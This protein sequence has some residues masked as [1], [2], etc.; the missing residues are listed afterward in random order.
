M[1]TK[2][3]NCKTSAN[4]V[5]LLFCYT[6][7]PDDNFLEETGVKNEGRHPALLTAIIAVSCSFFMCYVWRFCLS[8][9][10]FLH[11]GRSLDQN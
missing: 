9:L 7:L 3:L 2:H 6:V 4:S 5:I 10:V 11:T 1:Q 8:H